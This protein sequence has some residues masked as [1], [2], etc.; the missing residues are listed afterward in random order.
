VFLTEPRLTKNLLKR[1]VPARWSRRIGDHLRQRNLI[2]P[3]LSP[4]IR[5]QLIE[6]YREDIIKLQDMLQRDISHWLK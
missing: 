3:P 6:V 1:F 4:Q 5:R 2:K